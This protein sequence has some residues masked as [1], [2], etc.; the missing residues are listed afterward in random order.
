MPVN[1]KIKNSGNEFDKHLTEST[2]MAVKPAVA[3]VN[4]VKQ[5]TIPKV[6]KQQQTL[7]DKQETLNK[8]VMA[9]AGKLC[10]VH[11]QGGVT[12]NMG[13]HE[14]AK[15]TVG[16]TVPCAKEGLDDTYEF[17]TDWVSQKLEDSVKK[18]KGE[19]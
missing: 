14:F 10:E 18:V 2:S 5:T 9:P 19:A 1:F 13:D 7:V 12:L 11:V 3:T 4:V 16:I 6:G 17:A 15:I 8:G